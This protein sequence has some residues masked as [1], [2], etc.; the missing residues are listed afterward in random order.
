MRYPNTL[1]TLA[2]LFGAALLATAAA[3]VVAGPAAT[4]AAGTAAAGAPIF[5]VQ[6]P[7]TYRDGPQDGRLLL[8][9]APAEQ[10]P[11]E[12]PRFLVAWD[13]DAIPFFGIDVDA[14]KHG[15]SR[16]IDDTAFG[17]PVRTL[18]DLPPAIAQA[19]RHPLAATD[20]QA[21]IL[22]ALQTPPRG[23]CS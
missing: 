2:A 8:I 10:S 20:H 23:T 3:P 1:L 21:N 22:A 6:L 5:E 16:R 11:A 15:S 12:E 14:W 7:A 17:F 18:A 19:L 9:L 13:A 4:M